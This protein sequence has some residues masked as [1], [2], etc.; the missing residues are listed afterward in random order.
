MKFKNNAFNELENRGFVFQA[1]NLEE[2]KRILSEG[3]SP[4][5]LALT[6]QLMTC[7]LDT[8]LDFKWQR[9]C[10]I[11]GID[12]LCLLAERLLLLE[13]QVIKLT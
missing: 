3:L 13:I 11:V 5:T 4:F 1:T 10:K 8:F 7:T 12:V 6:L 9:F 2:T